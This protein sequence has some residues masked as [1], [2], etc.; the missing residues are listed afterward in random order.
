MGIIS[1]I[2][3]PRKDSRGRV[4][5]MEILIATPAIRNLI[6][7]AK[8]YQIPSSVQTGSQYGM[9]TMDH[10]LANLLRKGLISQQTAWE[11]A[12]DKKMFKTEK[13]FETID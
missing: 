11:Y 1:Q 12:T 6:R 13:E 7:E 10:C 5:A 8:S 2:L 3:I 9:Q 4:A